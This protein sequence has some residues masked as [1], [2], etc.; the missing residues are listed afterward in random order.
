MP[1]WRQLI[2]L[3]LS[4]LTPCGPA[5]ATSRGNNPGKRFDTDNDG[6]LT[7]MELWTEKN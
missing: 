1:P 5:L 6:T 7:M 4:A 2:A 3:L